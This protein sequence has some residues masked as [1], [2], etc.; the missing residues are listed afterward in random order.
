MFISD[1]TFSDI[2]LS[3][4]KP[5]CDRSSL[6][7]NPL[8]VIDDQRYVL[9]DDAVTGIKF[10]SLTYTPPCD[11]EGTFTYQAVLQD[12]NSIPIFLTFDPVLKEFSFYTDTL[13]DV[14]VYPIKVRVILPDG[15]INEDMVFTIT[16]T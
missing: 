9:G 2:V 4:L 1:Y 14:G 10:D 13:T 3:Q 5:P 16:V 12:G 6:V 8:T 15:T 11:E 7:I